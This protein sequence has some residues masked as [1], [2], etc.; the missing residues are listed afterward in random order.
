MTTAPEHPPYYPEDQLTDRNERFFCA[1]MIREKLLTHYQQE[2]PYSIEVVVDEFKQ[3][4]NVNQ[5]FCDNLLRKRFSESDHYWK[6]WPRV[7]KDWFGSTTRYG[8]IFRSKSV[9]RTLR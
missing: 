7:K 8:E 3:K 2:I 5:D 4:K 9:F 1:E 6:T